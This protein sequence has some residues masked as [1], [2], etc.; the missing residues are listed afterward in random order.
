MTPDKCP[1]CKSPI[2]YSDKTG[3]IYSCRLMAN[4]GADGVW[5][6]AQHSEYGARCTEIA[7]LREVIPWVERFSGTMGGPWPRL[8]T[9]LAKAKEIVE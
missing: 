9:W 8:A 4:V 2:I 6:V 5:Y 7:L 3:T 1:R